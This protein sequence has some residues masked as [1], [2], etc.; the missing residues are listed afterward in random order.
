M[1]FFEI[2]S[3]MTALTSLMTIQQSPGQREKQGARRGK[4]PVGGWG[5]GNAQSARESGGTVPTLSL[6]SGNILWD[7][8]WAQK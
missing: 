3:Y 6:T 7:F 8:I 1:R 5:K 2:D 4:L